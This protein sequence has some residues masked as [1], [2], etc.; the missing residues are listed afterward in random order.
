MENGPNGRLDDAASSEHSENEND[1]SSSSSVSVSSSLSSSSSSSSDQD[2]E[3]IEGDEASASPSPAYG[4]HV[5]KLVRRTYSL[6]A[7]NYARGYFV[8]FHP[9]TRR[10]KSAH[11]AAPK[12]SS[13]NLMCNWLERFAEGSSEHKCHVS[14]WPRFS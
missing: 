1:S 13:N 14:Q 9:T 6:V 4:V 2:Y 10:G 11:V 12:S 5:A 3:K 8:V 7:F